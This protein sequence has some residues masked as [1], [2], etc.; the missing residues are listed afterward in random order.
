VNII[1]QYKSEIV[2]LKSL[3]EQ[4]NDEIKEK[5]VELNQKDVELNQKN[6]ELEEKNTEI[7]SLRKL[8]DWYLEQFKLKQKEKFGKSSEKADPN[9]LDF[10]DIFNEAEIIKEPIVIEPELET[11]VKEHTR[12]KSKKGKALE[13][14]E[15]KQV[16]YDL[17]DEEKICDVCGE[18]LTEMKTE[19]RK[20][21]VIKPAETY[22]VEHITHVYSCRNC[23]KNGLDGFIKKA[24]HPKALMEKS[25]VS[26]ELL[27]YVMNQKYTLAQPLYRQEQEFH[28]LGIEL[29]RQNLSNWIIKGSGLLKPLYEAMKSSL[30]KEELLHADETPLEVLNEPGR[31]ATSKSYVWVYRTSEYN[32][33]PVVLYEYTQGRGSVFPKNFLKDWQ[34]KYLHC[35]GYVGYK[36]I[37]KCD[38]MWMFSA[39]KTKIS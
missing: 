7:Q 11:V 37:R 8:N 14:L 25:F 21:L 2:A 6:V 36:K 28:R 20:E 19:T 32:N 30:L 10:L 23:D 38:L 4:K 27:A 35:D 18:A 9:Q 15:T 1:E 31:K 33:N 17:A 29:S 26:P 12:K 24:P 39:C 5:D 13:N 34:G 3:L 22:V 16:H